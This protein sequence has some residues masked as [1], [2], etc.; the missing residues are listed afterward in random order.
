MAWNGSDNEKVKVEGQGQQRSGKTSAVHLHLS[1]S[2]NF[3]YKALVAGLIVVIGGGLA[4]WFF[5]GEK[6]ENGERGE[7]G[8]RGA[9]RPTTIAEVAPQIATNAAEAPDAKKGIRMENGVEVV[10]ANTTTNRNGAVIEYLQLADGTT[11]RKIRPPKPLFDNASD[12]L[13]AMA[14]SAKPGQ[15]MPPLPDLSNVDDDFAKSLL[16]PI[17]IEEGDS[18][19]V[20]ELKAKVMEARVYLGEEV[21]RGSTVREALRQYQADME[22]YADS[23]LMAVQQ[24]TEIRESE[25]EEAAAEF[26]KRVNESFRARGIPEL[27]MPQHK[28]TSK[29]EA[30]E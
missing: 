25:G 5:M 10:K 1:P 20:K 15:S 19:E 18:E 21:K 14:V 24:I 6:G 7:D 13:I 28:S 26:R 22:K 3:N 11:K 9:T 17:R 8:G 12:Q 29:E 4:A 30:K 2:P 23:H 16:S 27:E